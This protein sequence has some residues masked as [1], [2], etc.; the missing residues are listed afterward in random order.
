MIATRSFL[1]IGHSG[2]IATS[3]MNNLSRTDATT[4]IQ[5]TLTCD[6]YTITRTYEAPEYYD[7]EKW[8]RISEIEQLKA[9]WLKPHK[10]GKPFSNNSKINYNLPRS[11]LREKKQIFLKAA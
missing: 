2:Y 5:E 3:L 10:Q 8:S 1:V 6:V 11:R 7:Y 4:V 9:G